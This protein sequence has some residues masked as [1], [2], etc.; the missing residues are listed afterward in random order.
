MPHVLRHTCA[1]SALQ[2]TRNIRKAALW[3]GHASI[4]TTEVYLNADTQEK[5]EAIAVTP[6]QLKCGRFSAPDRLT[7]GFPNRIGYAED[8]DIDAFTLDDQICNN[9]GIGAPMATAGEIIIE[10]H[11]H[12]MMGTKGSITQRY[13]TVKMKMKGNERTISTL[14]GS[15][16]SINTS[17][18]SVKEEPRVSSRVTRE[19]GFQYEACQPRRRIDGAMIGNRTEDGVKIA[20]EWA[21]FECGPTGDLCPSLRYKVAG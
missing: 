13:M 20:G 2:A 5:L 9:P 18:G 12:V 15:K 21:T 1:V 16:W 8:R 10:Q 4:T 7:A 14:P 3:L 6:L 19:R 11:T 17:E